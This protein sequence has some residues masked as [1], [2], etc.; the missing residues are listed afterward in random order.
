MNLSENFAALRQRREMA[1]IAY[2]TAGYPT[3]S[4]FIAT[5]QTLIENGV[6]II[7]IGVP[8]SDPVADGPTIQASS[9][10]ALQNGVTLKKILAILPEL[11]SPIPLILMSYLNPLLAYGRGR[12]LNE[13]GAAQISGLIIPDLPVEAADEWIEAA[14]LCQIDP[15]FLITPT[16]T[17]ARIRLIADKSRGYI[18]CVRLTGITGSRTDELSADVF[19]LIRR[20]KSHTNLPVAIG[21]GISTPEQVRR[22]SGQADGVIIGSRIIKAMQDGEDVGA[23]VRQLKAATSV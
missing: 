21:F 4:A 11:K 12:L 5:V 10:I 16:S 13:L 18:Y 19:A 7:E 6:D 15:I 3:L 9:Q 1:L 23:L 14:M 20:I 22:L 8:F 17:D 2:L